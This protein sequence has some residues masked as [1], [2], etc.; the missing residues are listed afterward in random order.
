MRNF[1]DSFSIG[2]FIERLEETREWKSL[3]DK[4]QVFNNR[5]KEDVKSRGSHCY[6]VGNIAFELTQQLDGD[7]VT[8]DKARLIGLIH[9]LGHIPYGHAGESVATDIIE[10][11]K[12]TEEEQ[13]QIMTVRRFLF[14]NDYVDKCEKNICFEH[15]ENSVLQYIT[16]CNRFG[17]E[18]D[19]EIII[20]ILS[21]STS[22]YKELPLS[23]SQQA[24][25]LADKL[26][27]IN[28]DVDDLFLSFEGKEE[29][30]SALRK[31]YEEPLLD[32]SG[33]EIKVPFNGKEYTL[34]EFL[35]QLSSADRIKSFVDASVMDA[36]NQSLRGIDKY[37]NYGTILTG[38]NDI[39][40]EIAGLR[41]DKKKTKEEVEKIKIDN[42]IEELRVELY[43][44]SPVLY[45][46]YEI[47][48]RSDNFIR[49]GIGLT[50]ES[51]VDRSMQSISSVGNKDLMNEYFYKS[52][53][54]YLER[55]TKNNVGLSKEQII[56]KYRLSD[57]PQEYV[58][59]YL[60]YLDFKK[61]Q[62]DLIANLPGNDGTLYPEIYTIVNFIGIHSNT[63]LT[64]LAKIGGLRINFE[65]EVLP[66][67]QAL[68]SNE[69][70]YDSKNGVFTK[71]GNE[72]REEL[73][74]KYGAQIKVEFGLEEENIIS[75]ASDKSIERTMEA[76]YNV[77]DY[78]PTVKAIS[79]EKFREVA[80]TQEREYIESVA[81]LV[82][83][84]MQQYENLEE[85][86]GK[87]R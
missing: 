20:G 19:E 16:L 51:Q 57:I 53:V 10:K 41:K 26:A 85:E 31:M 61:E 29:E 64:R 83:S 52:I 14:G 48:E 82:K 38:C 60:E 87:N 81:N 11:Y 77:P 59:L 40:V 47:K 49:S 18:P 71:A 62:N 8:C 24:V 36:K 13:A 33:K 7:F 21:H 80:S 25:R 9:D 55:E 42:K 78:E 44:R 46:A 15:N 32:P 45:A 12:F 28:Y 63:Q 56:E 67:V 30:M 3:Q 74:S 22:R 27:Y 73:V 17:F 35:T 37:K 68:I 70:Y 65:R 34:Y 58:D 79:V 76:G 75:V 86:K 2:Y 72:A 39:I 43:R 66:Q 50:K 69:E 6:D 23:L 84:Q 1:N 4:T 5:I 54:L